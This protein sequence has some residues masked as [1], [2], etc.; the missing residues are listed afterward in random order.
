MIPVSLRPLKARM[1]RA[2]RTVDMAIMRNAARHPRLAALY[3]ALFSGDLSREAAAVLAGR[4]RYQADVS[5]DEG[6]SFLL[7][8]NVHRL[9]K[10]LIMRPLRAI[11]ALDYIEETISALERATRHG[12]YDDEQAWAFDVLDSYF[13]KVDGTHPT[14]GAQKDRYRII[15]ARCDP[16]TNDRAKVPY[17]RMLT[18]DPPVPFDDLMTLSKRRR[19]VRWFRQEHVPRELV[20]QALRVAKEAPSA[21]NRQPFVYRVFDDP[22]DARRLAAIPLGTKGFSDQLTGLAIVVGRLRAYPESRDRHAIYIDGSLSAMA[23][24]YALETLGLSSCPINWPDKEPQE[25]IMRRELG[26]APDERV[27]MLIAY[28]WPDPA[29]LVPYSAKRVHD[30]IRTYG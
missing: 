28:G 8:R 22:A 26:L 1:R 13:A 11:F 15:R 5:S 18:G 12:S 30:Q 4:I 21:C 16:A 25:S 20:D 27:I 10:G 2:W 3:F 24:M 14:I 7:R 29:G 19:S 17:A 9:E 23:F 6:S